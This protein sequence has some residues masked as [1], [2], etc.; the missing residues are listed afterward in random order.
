MYEDTDTSDNTTS[1]CTVGNLEGLL[2]GGHDFW[3][4]SHG[5]NV[6]EAR[7]DE[8]ASDERYDGLVLLGYG[9]YIYESTTG[10]TGSE[11]NPKRFVICLREEGAEEWSTDKKQIMFIGGCGTSGHIDDYKGGLILGYWG[12]PP[13]TDLY[14]DARKLFQ[15]MSGRTG[16]GGL[17]RSGDTLTDLNGYGYTSAFRYDGLIKNDMVLA[18]AVKDVEP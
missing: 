4:D 1:P 7:G 3:I 17:R 8:E 18:P 10:A 2:L 15:Y 11:T 16:L 12:S 6:I 13:T 5:G 9:D 14:S